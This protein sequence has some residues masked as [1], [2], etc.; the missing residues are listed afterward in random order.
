[1]DPKAVITAGAEGLKTMVSVEQLSGALVAYDKAIMGTF[2][3]G[4]AGAGVAFFWAFGIERG[5]VKGAE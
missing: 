1:V 5:S 2:Y 3:L 4:V